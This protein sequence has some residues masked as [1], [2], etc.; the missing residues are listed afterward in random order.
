V[1]NY[2]HCKFGTKIMTDWTN[3]FESNPGK[4]YG[5]PVIKNTRIPVN[6]IL[7]KLGAGDSM[8]NLL[9]AYPTITKEDISACLLFAADTVKNETLVPKVS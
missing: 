4:L 6:I 1:K 2:I 8:E 3:H 5:K 7:E 9:E